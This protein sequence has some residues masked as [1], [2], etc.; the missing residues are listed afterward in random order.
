MYQRCIN[1]LQRK[2]HFKGRRPLCTLGKKQSLGADASNARQDRPL[3]GDA[4]PE[5]LGLA[6]IG[7]STVKDMVYVKRPS[8]KEKVEFLA[9]ELD[10]YQAL[11]EAQ[12]KAAGA[13]MA[14]TA[15]L[16]VSASPWCCRCL[17]EPTSPALCE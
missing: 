8:R 10:V 11:E 16:C 12:E 6:G 5:T 4:G 17:Q 14:G 15:T 3:S 9:Q 7:N 1:V 13:G 2:A